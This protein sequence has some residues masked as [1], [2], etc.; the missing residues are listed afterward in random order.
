[1]YRELAEYGKELGKDITIT[2]YIIWGGFPKRIEYSVENGQR[3]YLNELNETIILNDIINRYKIRKTEVFKRL[4]Y[5]KDFGILHTAMQ[6]AHICFR[7]VL[8]CL[9][10]H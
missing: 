3:I 2:D 4:K 10:T 1:M 7:R 5:H 6:L 9:K 8:S